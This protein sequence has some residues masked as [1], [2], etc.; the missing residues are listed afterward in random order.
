MQTSVQSATMAAKER[1]W[2][3]ARIGVPVSA[4]KAFCDRW[5]VAFFGIG[6]MQRE[7]ADLLVRGVDLV[8]RTAIEERRNHIRPMAILESARGVYAA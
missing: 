5:R 3:A 2:L 6:G 7:L 4:I 8:H 1:E